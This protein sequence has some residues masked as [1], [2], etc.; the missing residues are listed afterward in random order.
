MVK[1]GIVCAKLSITCMFCHRTENFTAAMIQNQP[2][3]EYSVSHSSVETALSDLDFVKTPC[4]WMHKEC[5]WRWCAENG[6]DGG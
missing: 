4:G 2:S 1:D 6:P 5:Q 3:L